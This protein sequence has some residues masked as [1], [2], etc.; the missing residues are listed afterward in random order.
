MATLAPGPEG[1]TL[2]SPP[3]GKSSHSLGSDGK[4]PHDTHTLQTPVTEVG[5]VLEPAGVKG[6]ILWLGGGKASGELSTAP[7][8]GLTLGLPSAWKA[9]PQIEWL[10]L[11]LSLGLCSNVSF[12][13]RP[14]LASSPATGAHCAL[15]WPV[16]SL[17]HVP[18]WPLY[19]SSCACSC[20]VSLPPEYQLHRA[21][22]LSRLFTAVPPVPRTVPGAW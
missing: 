1:K 16:V 18:H 21:E 13:V 22:P 4:H 17:W 19:L 10:P 12:S 15:N 6:L 3:G 8:P 2:L 14:F 11:L 9:L 20:P 7:L 5:T